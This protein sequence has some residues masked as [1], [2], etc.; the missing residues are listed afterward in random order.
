MKKVRINGRISF[1]YCGYYRPVGEELEG[2]GPLRGLSV[3]FV[4]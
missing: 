2:S 3:R 4:L 1:S